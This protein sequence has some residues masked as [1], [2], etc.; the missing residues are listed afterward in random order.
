MGHA[1]AAGKLRVTVTL[2]LVMA[3]TLSPPL[4]APRGAE[5]PLPQLGKL[6]QGGVA[7][8][9]ALGSGIKAASLPPC[10]EHPWA[11]GAPCSP[12]TPGKT[13]AEPS[14]SAEPPRSR[15]CC[16]DRSA[17]ERLRLPPGLGARGGPAASPLVHS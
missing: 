1:A 8:A 17:P 16:W 2:G 10:P 5:P 7:E 13:R 12:P 14:S 11:V 6:R 15:G 3:V 9:E 4:P